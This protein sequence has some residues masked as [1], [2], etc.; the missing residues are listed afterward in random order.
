MS[1]S[2]PREDPGE[3]TRVD[4]LEETGGEAELGQ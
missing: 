3:E 2:P 1:A 4:E